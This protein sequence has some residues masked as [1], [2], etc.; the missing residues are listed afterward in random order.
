MP[1]YTTDLSFNF[2][3]PTKIVFGA[4]AVN[5]IGPEMDSL[6]KKRAVIITDEGLAATGMIDRAKDILGKRC[7]GIFPEVK[8]D[9]GVYIIDKAVKYAKGVDADILIS[10]GGGSSID[11]AKAMAILLTEGGKLEDY[12]GWQILKRPLM[13]HIAV[14]TTAGTGSEV[15]YVAVVK[16]HDRGIKLV[17]GDNHLIPNTAIL[18]PELTVNLPPDITASTGMD[19][20]SHA[21]ESIH[22]LQRQPMTDGLAL[23][24][25]RMIFNYLAISVENGKDIAARGQM[26]IAA[27]MAGIAFSNAQLGIVHAMAHAVGARFGVPHG[28]ANAILLPYGMEYNLGVCEKEYAAIAD[29]AGIDVH[30]KTKREAAEMAIY[31]VK[32]L[33]EE[34]GLPTKLSDV[35]VTKEGFA[36]CAENAMADP[37]IVYNSRTPS[38]PDDILKLLEKAW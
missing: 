34:I 3:S 4:G 5:D 35:N 7:V 37:S 31:A 32:R 30:K 15:T 22:S 33:T 28:V 23:Q 36:I 21:I 25:I 27:T 29:A 2:N 38:G 11:T 6:N 26:Q 1:N 24:A 10:I 16:D 12:Q 17:F 18:D 19:A 13:P 8:P 20:L 14:P 9:T